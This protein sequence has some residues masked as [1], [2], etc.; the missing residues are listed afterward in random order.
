VGTNDSVRLDSTSGLGEGSE[1]QFFCGKRKLGEENA[2][3]IRLERAPLAPLEAELREIS[4][5][6][7]ARLQAGFPMPASSDRE[8]Q[9]TAIHQAGHVQM[10]E[11]IGIR[12]HGLWLAPHPDMPGR[13]LGGVNYENCLD[14]ATPDVRAMIALAGGAA[15]SLFDPNS[16]AVNENDQRQAFEIC[17]ALRNN[18]EGA[19]WEL[20]YFLCDGAEAVLGRGAFWVQVL[21][22]AFALVDRRRLS[23]DELLEIQRRAFERLR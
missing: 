17:K 2:M 10:A 1:A 15:E 19:A 11:M 16:P 13:W 23:R 21:A 3:T 12:V 20:F 6:E 8:R 14:H 7:R 4:R 5:V 22:V 9:R 18:E